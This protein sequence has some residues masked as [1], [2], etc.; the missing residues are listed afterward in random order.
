MDSCQ[1]GVEVVV[2]TTEVVAPFSPLTVQRLPMLNLDLLVPLCDNGILFLYD[3]HQSMM[4]SLVKKGLSQGG[5]EILCNNRGVDFVQ[6][7]ADVNL[8]H[9][10][11]YKLDV[12]VYPKFFPVKTRGVLS[13]QVTEMR[14]GGLVIGCTFDHRVADGHSV[15][16]FIAAWA[17][18]TRSNHC[19][20]NKMASSLPSPEYLSSFLLPRKPIRPDLAMHN[21]YVLFEAASSDSPQAPPLVHLQSRIYKISACQIELLQSLAG[22]GRTKFES[23]SALLFRNCSQWTKFFRP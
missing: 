14:C 8:Q 7:I 13:V 15:S 1:R 23:F 4:I 3:K 10:D 11:L 19:G 21:K 22:P 6:A 16:N 20:D 9:L 17:N 12:A 18:M 5:P 2:K